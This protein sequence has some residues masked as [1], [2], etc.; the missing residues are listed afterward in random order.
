MLNVD[1][2]NP[3]SPKNLYSLL[4]TSLFSNAGGYPQG[5]PF[6]LSSLFEAQRKSLK[7]LAEAQEIT[8]SGIQAVT[9]QQSDI[10]SGMIESQSALTNLLIQ[11]GT[12]EEKIARH[13]EATRTQYK[14]T[15]RDVRDM[16][17]TI[18]KTIRNAADALHQSVISNLGETVRVKS[19]NALV[20]ANSKTDQ[21]GKIAA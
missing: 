9:R 21:H 19:K 5:L 8:I 14:E 2:K 1:F 4:T 18:N 20:P 13:A 16:Q 15:L 7:A 11:Q 6:D 10:L 3:Y 17:D 12:P